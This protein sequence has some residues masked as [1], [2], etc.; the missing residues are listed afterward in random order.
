MSA[1]KWAGLFYLT[2]K[3][4][5]VWQQRNGRASVK[6]AKRK[7]QNKGLTTDFCSL[8]LVE[9]LLLMTKSVQIGLL[10]SVL[11]LGSDEILFP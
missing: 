3:S 11:S 2:R 4:M 5:F 6:T 8:Q 1:M 9:R 10:T 7:A